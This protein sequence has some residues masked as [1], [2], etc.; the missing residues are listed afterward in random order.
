MVAKNRADDAGLDCLHYECDDLNEYPWQ[1][2]AFDLVISNG[3]LHHLSKLDLV[4]DGIK[5]ALKPG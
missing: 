4:L 1:E 2:D 5:L 3:A